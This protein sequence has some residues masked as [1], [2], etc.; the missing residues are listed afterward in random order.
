MFLCRKPAN[1]T[2]SRWVEEA[3]LRLKESKALHLWNKKNRELITGYGSFMLRLISDHYF[4]C[5]HIHH[6][7]R[8]FL[9]Q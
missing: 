8:K 4:V 5:Q 2:T 7:G 9:S 1:R 3:L 6:S